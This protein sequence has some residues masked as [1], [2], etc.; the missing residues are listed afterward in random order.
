MADV[1]MWSKWQ[2]SGAGRR[3]EGEGEEESPPHTPGPQERE[4][5]LQ[6]GELQV[7]G[8]SLLMAS[9]LFFCLFIYFLEAGG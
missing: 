7:V 3:G 2:P 5:S 1:H 4:I 8:S 9:I 6:A